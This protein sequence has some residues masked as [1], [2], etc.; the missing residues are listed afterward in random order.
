MN[1]GWVWRLVDGVN[2]LWPSGVTT[3]TGLF[4]G[5]T[6][7]NLR[8]EIESGLRELEQVAAAVRCYYGLFWPPGSS[9]P[10]RPLTVQSSTS[11]H[12]LSSQRLRPARPSS[13]AAAGIG[14]GL[15]AALVA[16]APAAACAPAGP[17]PSIVVVII[18]TL[19]ADHIGSYGY[20]ENPTTPNL[21]ARATSAALFERAFSTAPW[22]LPAIGSILTGQLPARHAAG[23]RFVS[24]ADSHAAGDPGSAPATELVDHGRRIF[25][26]LDDSIPTLAQRLTDAGYATAA[27]VNNSFL[28]PEFGLERGFATYDYDA[29]RP[30]RRAADAS[31][32][33][34][35]WLA[36]RPEGDEPLFLLLH[37]FDPHMKYG[38]PP[39]FLGRFAGRHAG[40]QFALPLDDFRP[41]RA[42]IRERAEGWQRDAA[43]QEALYDEE[44]AYVD[45]QLERVLDVLEARGFFEHGYLVVTSDH[46]EEFQ[47]HGGMEHG[48]TLYN[49]LIRVPFLVWGPGVVPG[50]YPLPVSLVDVMPTLLEAARLPAEPGIE[51]VSLWQVL[52]EGPA[53]ARAS[54]LPFD[55][56]LF[57]ERPLYG[58]AKKAVIRWPW[59]LLAD[60]GD[61]AEVAFD[62]ETDPDENDPRELIDLD[63]QGQDRLLSMLAVL[64]E[65]MTRTNP[66][67]G[68]GAVLSEATIRRLR[69]LGYIR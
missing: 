43:L 25:F 15:I 27:I 28:A 64:Q 53:T 35:A 23:G 33:A 56:P 16:A 68:E 1:V 41:L 26:R 49:E 19:R 31:D 57:A 12:D 60:L 44:I 42:S 59:K 36:E 3:S 13:R 69:E 62:L 58:D 10:N 8:D 65:M 2:M 4:P 11:G 21:D 7:T 14:C 51:G 24:A 50:R 48:H 34:L 46:G 9:A 17:P 40:D 30:E 54:A 5:Q 32:R 63:A 37:Y 18:D 47:D 6:G 20:G 22:T 66:D 38:A 61:Q 67:A 52:E 39:P 55:R 45:H 29:R